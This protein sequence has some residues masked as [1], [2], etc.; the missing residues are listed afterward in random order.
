MKIN[1]YIFS[2]KICFIVSCKPIFFY[3]Q[4]TNDHNDYIQCVFLTAT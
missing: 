2:L 3:L 4:D 1:I